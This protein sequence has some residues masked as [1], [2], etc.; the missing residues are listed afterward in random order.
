MKYKGQ[1]KKI[2]GSTKEREQIRIK[3]CKNRLKYHKTV[4]IKKTN[5]ST[6]QRFSDLK[7]PTK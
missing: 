7:N 3:I 4:V 1:K 2:E 6:Q 5:L